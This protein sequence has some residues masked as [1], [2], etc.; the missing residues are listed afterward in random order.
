MLQIIDILYFTL[1]NPLK[2][3]HIARKQNALIVRKITHLN[4][5]CFTRIKFVHLVSTLTQSNFYQLWL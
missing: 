4:Y 5:P 1:V 3:D 2:A